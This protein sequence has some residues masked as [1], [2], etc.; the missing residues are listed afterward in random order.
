MIPL[1]VFA[2]PPR[3]GR[4]K[5]RLGETLG[6]A[7]AAALYAAFLE[8][9]LTHASVG[10]APELHVAGDP[11]DPALLGVPGA[12]SLPRHA[13]VGENLGA[14]MQHALEVALRRAP[15]ALL[16]G[17]DAP[18]IGGVLPHLP[19]QLGDAPLGLGPTRDGGYYVVAARAAPRFDDVRWST[20]Y[21]L[22]DTCRAN[23]EAALLAPHY[24]VDTEDDLELLRLHLAID[25]TAAPATH[26]ALTWSTEER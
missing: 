20:S 7:R 16:I 15:L 9:V 5:T 23:P 17:S 22:A 11:D 12:R 19:A 4:V 21:A 24:D 3:S 2:K 8:D 13:Q 25:P 6:H 26:R 14:R 10:F 1:L 18:T